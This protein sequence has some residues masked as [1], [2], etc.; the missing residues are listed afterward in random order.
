MAP[1]ST[2]KSAIVEVNDLNFDDEVLQSPLPVFV[3]VTARWCAPCKTAK[4]VVEELAERYHGRLKIVEVDGGESPDIAARLDV[5][6]FPTFIGIV[7]GNV[8]ERVA[9][10]SGAKALDVMANRLASAVHD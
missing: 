1:K 4:P 7:G 3:D 2:P 10:F 6:G 5:R 8:V 9:G